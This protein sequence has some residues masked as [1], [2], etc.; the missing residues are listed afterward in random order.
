LC[1]VIIL[2]RGNRSF[3][4]PLDTPLVSGIRCSVA[5][6]EEHPG[7]AVR[8]DQGG[9]YRHGGSPL[10]DRDETEAVRGGHLHRCLD[11]VDHHKGRPIGAVE[12]KSP[13]AITHAGPHVR[14]L[15]CAEV[16]QLF[17]G[18]VAERVRLPI[19]GSDNCLAGLIR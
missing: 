3:D 1:V 18:D 16:K 15:A 6:I 2:E 17:K 9:D 10:M 13:L 5:A 11:I 7:Y 4:R 14:H 12:H 8:L 19:F